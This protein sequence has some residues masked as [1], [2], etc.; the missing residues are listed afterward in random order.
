[1]GDFNATEVRHHGRVLS[2]GAW[3]TGLS[4]A[5]RSTRTLWTT[6]SYWRHLGRVSKS[7]TSTAMA[8]RHRRPRFGKSPVVGRAIHRL[9][10]RQSAVGLLD[11]GRDWV[12]VNGRDFNGHARPTSSAGPWQSASV[13]SAYPTQHA[14]NTT[15][16]AMWSTAS[17]GS[18][19][20]S[21]DFNGG[22]QDRHH[23]APGDRPVVHRP[24]QRQHRF[25]HHPLDHLKH[26]LSPGSTSA[27]AI[28][29]N[30]KR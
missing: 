23:R 14:F 19:S 29:R 7:A 21:G 17:L 26:R 30:G 1:V 12:D 2:N 13:G 28:L 15:L 8:V 11:H 4:A 16:W 9:I 20:K 24:L 5:R 18:T 3:W 25:Q 10:L 6:W 27:A 22:R